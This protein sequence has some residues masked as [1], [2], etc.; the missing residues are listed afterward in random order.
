M[1]ETEHIQRCD[2][3]LCIWSHM[4]GALGVSPSLRAAWGVRSSEEMR[5]AT[6]G[7]A[8]SAIDAWH[9]MT[10]AEQQNCVPYDGAFISTFVSCVEWNANTTPIANVP[11]ETPRALATAILAEASRTKSSVLQ[12]A[13]TLARLGEWID[14][15]TR[16][17][18]GAE[19]AALFAR[20]RKAG[21]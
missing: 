20:V 21:D 4:L 7:L 10:H 16:D 9:A 1:I 13:N 19:T 5:K 15:M 14:G 3:A 18:L 6:I 11:Y 8:N 12:P 2:T 17:D